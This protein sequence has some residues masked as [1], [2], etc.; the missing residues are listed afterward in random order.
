MKILTY[1]NNNY[2]R[3]RYLFLSYYLL[4]IDKKFVD[5][6]KIIVLIISFTSIYTEYFTVIL[7]Q[8]VLL[9]FLVIEDPKNK[10]RIKSLFRVCTPYLV[11]GVVLANIISGLL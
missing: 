3:P 5:V 9:A 2:N 11:I 6:S 10:T 4:L 1:S 8:A 7:I